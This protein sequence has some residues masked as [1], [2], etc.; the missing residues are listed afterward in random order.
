[1]DHDVFYKKGL[2]GLVNMGNT[3]FMNTIIQ[4]MNS[5][6]DFAKF[7]LQN[8]YQEYI[9]Y[10]NI[11]HALVMQWDKVCKQLYR[12]NCVFSPQTFLETIKILALKKNR[13][14]FTGFAQNDSQEFLQFF[15]E[16][17]HNGLSREVI[18]TIK[19]IPQ[20]PQEQRTV[21]AHK[22][23]IQFFKNDYSEIVEFFYGQFYS[24]IQ[25]PED[26]N[27]ISEV[28]EPFSNLSLEIPDTSML[29][30]DVL[31]L[32][33]C[34]E[35]FCQ[36]ENL[37][38]HRQSDEDT[39]TY[40]RKLTFWK[41]PDYLIIF[42]KRY[43]NDLD[44]NDTLIQFPVSGLDMTP[45]CSGPFSHNLIYDLHAV[46]NHSGSLKSG[47]YWAYC[48]NYDTN[49]YCFNDRYV[50]HLKPENVV[51]KNAYCI[52]YKRRPSPKE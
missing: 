10:S 42:F 3:C 1:M 2:C 48:K 38:D 45:Y 41:I 25:S 20:T 19:G 44:L 27:Y 39:K 33:D 43:D 5:N 21:D 36:T 50:T 28:Y 34:M 7:F 9:N 32:D 8:K 15:L 16:A 26:P 52:F 46:A 40:T 12:K 22:S 47:H 49:W 4:C 29:D 35:H 37:E 18:M 24:V 13:T 23:W 51:S 6:H 30:E 14:L 11:D 17:M 31:S